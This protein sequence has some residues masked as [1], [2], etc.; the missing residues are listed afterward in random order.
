MI[1]VG[2]HFCDGSMTENKRIDEK[3]DE[4]WIE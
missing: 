1:R 2:L 3:F 4:T